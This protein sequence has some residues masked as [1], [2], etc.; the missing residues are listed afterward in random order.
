MLFNLGAAIY[1]SKLR[2][3]NVHGLLNHDTYL[4]ST[5]GALSIYPKCFSVVLSF[6]VQMQHALTS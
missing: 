6:P 4:T 1:H 5:T 2:N 3:G